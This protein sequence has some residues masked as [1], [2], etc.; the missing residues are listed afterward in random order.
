MSA[1]AFA[2]AKYEANTGTIYNILIQPE[3]ETLILNGVTNTRPTGAVTPGLTRAQVSGSRRTY[4]VHTRLVRFKFTGTL[5]DGYLGGNSTLTLP[6]LTMSMYNGLDDGQTGTYTINGTA[7][8]VE[9]VGRT[10]ERIR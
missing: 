7:Y 6:V 3:T 1:G 10:P 4:G 2:K 8:D 5:P 9:F